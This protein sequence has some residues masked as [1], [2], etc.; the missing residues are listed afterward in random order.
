MQQIREMINGLSLVRKI[1]M[2]L[3]L[4][5]SVGVILFLVRVSNQSNMEPLFT[6]LNSQDMGQI[7]TRLDKS[8][9]LYEVD[10]EKRTVFVPATKVLELRVK[11]AE[12][13]LPR[14][15]GIGF[16]IFDK[17]GFGM[18][19]FEQRVNYQRALEGELSRTIA[20][21]KEI[22]SARVH[23]VLPEKSLFDESA[24]RSTASVIVKLGG[25]G[26]LSKGRVS[27]ITHLV[28]SAVENL[29]ASQVTVVDTAGKLL[30]S[31]NGDD[32]I[33]AGNQAFD[34]KASIERSYEDRIVALL[35]PVVGYGKVI[36]RV[37]TDIDFTR[38]D[39]TTE[40]VDPTK[41]AIL[42]E[43]RTTGN[44]KEST[45]SG[46]GN[47]GAGANLP[48]G[49]AG[50]TSGSGGASSDETSEE[51]TYA[52]S[53]TKT[54]RMTPIGEIKKLSVAILVDG[55]YDKKEDGEKTYK[56]RTEDEINKFS[57]LVKNAIGFSTDRGD[58]I[59]VDNIAFLDP[60]KEI[61]AE[62]PWFE[63]RT[64]N[65]FLMNVIGNSI[66]VVVFLLIFFFVIR[67]LMRAWRGEDSGDG[68]DM[69]D[70]TAEIGQLVKHNPTAAMN[71]IRQWINK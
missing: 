32:S 18:S 62:E 45:N 57:D 58:Q 59:K 66:A 38:V 7:I 23:L 36:A 16:E 1:S 63:K 15:G 68:V 42:K 37:T 60:E 41:S 39:T 12:E 26:T 30:T 9:Q 5:V 34:Q 69:V 44:S 47:S 61:A 53:R 50:G 21:I 70:G 6:N 17:S 49:N 56:A 71:A 55:T 43:S 51:I 64:D 28:A 52:V 27:S 46:G 65:A 11:L 54:R 24:E 20:G 19:D 13:G 67:P 35:S 29:N 10:Q 33:A 14:F 8:G 25:G 2:L 48:G 31:S 4:V 40:N 3:V 22:E